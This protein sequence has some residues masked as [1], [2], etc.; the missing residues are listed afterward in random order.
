MAEV[1]AL[2]VACPNCGAEIGRPCIDASTGEPKEAPCR[3]RKQV[4]L[5]HGE[6]A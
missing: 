5:G 3:V 6:E 1:N 2:D 4:A